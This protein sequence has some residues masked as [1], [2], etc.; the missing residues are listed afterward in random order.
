MP[1][2]GDYG[3]L[4]SSMQQTKTGGSTRQSQT[5]ELSQN[6]GFH[7][8]PPPDQDTGLYSYDLEED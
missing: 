3:W 7:K 8:F 5:W 4:K 6:G 1:V 2:N